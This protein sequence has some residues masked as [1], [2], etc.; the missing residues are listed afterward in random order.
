M[1]LLALLGRIQ[2]YLRFVGREASLSYPASRDA[3]IEAAQ[4][5]D[6]EIELFL[7][8]EDDG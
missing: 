6:A 3:A 2:D 7:A 1:R 5:L 4:A 8:E